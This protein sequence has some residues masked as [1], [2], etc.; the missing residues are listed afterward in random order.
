MMRSISIAKFEEGIT[1]EDAT[2]AR[3]E[4]IAVSDG[5][6][7]GGVFAERWS[8]YLVNHLP[9]K[10]IK[11]YKAFDKWIDAI[12]E[13]FYNEYETKAK[14]IGG[15]F[16]NKFYD[17]G[18]FATLA[19]VWKDGSWISYGDSVAFCYNLQT[20]DLQHSFTQLVDFNNPPYL[21]NCKDPLNPDGFRYGKF[22]KDKKS[23]VFTASDTLAHYI[24][25]MYEVSNKDR[26]AEE[27]QKAI[28]AQTKNS[29]FIK[30]AMTMPLFDFEKD[31]VRKLQNCS[32]S[33]L[34][35]NHIKGLRKKGLIGHDDYSLAMF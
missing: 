27:L 19:A 22:C 14:A 28:D 3:K 1:N 6:G 26:F 2:I 33:F 20:G 35:K 24:L 31:V 32:Q 15:L 4:V 17:E 7:G 9:D 29:N 30:T 13:P 34:M 11:N 21:I 12:W 23:V 10:P 18:S 16:L 8:N 5:A 25:M